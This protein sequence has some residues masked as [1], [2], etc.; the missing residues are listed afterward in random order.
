M[1]S[2]EMTDL[3]HIVL[4]KQSIDDTYIAVYVNSDIH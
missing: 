3:S 1:F 2:D 4:V